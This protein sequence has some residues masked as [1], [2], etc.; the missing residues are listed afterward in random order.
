MSAQLNVPRRDIYLLPG[1]HAVGDAHCRIRTLLG[2]CVSITLWHPR[3]RVGAMSH[4]VLP[5]K[6]PHPGPELNGRYGEDALALM[7]LDLE[8][9]G[10]SPGDCQAKLFGGGA[11][12]DPERMHS[13]VGRKNGEAARGMLFAHRIR[14]V[15]ESLFDACHRQI[16][17]CVDS[18][19]VW[20]RHGKAA[21][22]EARAMEHS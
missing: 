5:G 22:G 3:L 15:S 7:Q 1:E 17:F 14:V 13:D 18:G 6:S 19:E 8:R 2:S 9:L 16:I 11:M 12:F 21:G 10:A 20:V 4:F